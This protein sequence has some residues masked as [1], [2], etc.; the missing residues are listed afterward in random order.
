MPRP[1]L[2]RRPAAKTSGVR[3]QRSR[4]SLAGIETAP[5]RREDLQLGKPRQS[6][7]RG[8]HGLDLLPREEPSGHNLS[9]VERSA[10]ERLIPDAKF[11]G[12]D[13]HRL[14]IKRRRR[15]PICPG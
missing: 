8:K 5:E 2:E 10:V 15:A 3:A 14:A 7:C 1:N 13:K 12:A 4:P 11:G 9:E 6:R